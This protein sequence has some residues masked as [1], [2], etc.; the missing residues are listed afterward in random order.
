MGS[1]VSVDLKGAKVAVIGRNCHFEGV[2]CVAFIEIALHFTRT[3]AQ[4]CVV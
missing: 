2:E 1:I 3:S 4:I